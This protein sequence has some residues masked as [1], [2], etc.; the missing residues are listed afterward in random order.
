MVNPL[1]LRLVALLALV[2]GGASLPAQPQEIYP[3]RSGPSAQ[4]LN[5]SWQFKY[6]AG[7]DLGADAAFSDPGFAGAGAWQPIAV[8]G[9]WELQGFAEPKYGKTLAEG[10]GLYRRTFRAVEAWRGQRV[11]LRFDGVLFGFDAWVDG[12][13]V[14]TWASG[15]NPCTFDITDALK[16]GGPNHVLAVQVTTRDKGWEF[17]TNYFLSISG[18]YRH[19]LIFALAETHFTGWTA[20]AAVTPEGTA[21]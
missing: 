13:K 20:Q 21:D 11:F 10:T 9:H 4:S 8:P 6:L 12:V 16:S 5:G 1:C 18:I 15:Y 17:Y 7:S 2:A 14:G 19:G 3:V